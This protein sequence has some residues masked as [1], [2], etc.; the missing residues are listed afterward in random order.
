MAA[1]TSRSVVRLLLGDDRSVST[2]CST[3][4]FAIGVAVPLALLAGGTSA[5]VPALPPRYLLSGAM[6]VAT[7]LAMANA[8]LGGGLLVSVGV[9]LL[10]P[11]RVAVGT[12]VLDEVGVE[13]GL[14]PTVS[15][16]EF[17][18]VALASAL[19]AYAVGR[20]AGAHGDRPFPDP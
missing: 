10:L 16:P 17:L 4:G 13:L 15:V 9:V 12:L 3:V 8:Y 14:A 5:L 7:A 6:G 11:V 18:F 2:F 20:L 1:G 19:A